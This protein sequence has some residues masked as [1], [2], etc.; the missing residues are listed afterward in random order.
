MDAPKSLTKEKQFE[1]FFNK[2]IY[3]C[4]LRLNDN[5]MKIKIELLSIT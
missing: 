5:Q 1:I 4:I 3:N 2:N